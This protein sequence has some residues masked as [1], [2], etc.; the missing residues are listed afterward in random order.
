MLSVVAMLSGLNDIATIAL[1]VGSL[2]VGCYASASMEVLGAG[3]PGLNRA[4]CNIAAVGVALPWVAL[5]SV[6]VG[7]WLF[8]GDVPAYLYAAYGT[9]IALAVTAGVVQA[10]RVKGSGK[11]A[12]ATYS[13]QVLLV[14]AFV[15]ASAVAWQVFAGALQP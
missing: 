2:F 14:L 12:D 11:F 5:G 1:L 3:R 9:G 6:L 4:L 7:S 13:E 8:D 15:T 10:K